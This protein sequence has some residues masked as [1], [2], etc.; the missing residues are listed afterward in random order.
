L[1]ANSFEKENMKKFEL[2]IVKMDLESKAIQVQCTIPIEINSMKKYKSTSVESF[3]TKHIPIIERF[4]I[5]F[6]FLKP[7]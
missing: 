3:I 1:K 2:G 4:A 6:S 7:N 5:F